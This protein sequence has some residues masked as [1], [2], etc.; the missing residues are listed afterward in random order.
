M[1]GRRAAPCADQ[2]VGQRALRPDTAAG[3][4]TFDAQRATAR[5]VLAIALAG[6]LVS[7]VATAV[8]GWLLRWTPGG[9]LHA[10]LWS[11]TFAGVFLSVFNLV[12]FK[13]QER[14]SARPFYSD[15]ML[16]LEAL[17]LMRGG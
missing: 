2:G 15:G 7:L 11:L 4:A 3:T 16:A 6:P 12:P 1:Q 14:G 5:D 10:V 9:A 13:V 8:T 17:R